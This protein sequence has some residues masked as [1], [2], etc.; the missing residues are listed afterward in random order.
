MESRT[1]HRI[2]QRIPELDGWRVLLVFL[3]SWYHIWQQSWLTPHIGSISLDFLLRS[4]YM[5]VDG[6]VL[7]SGFLLFLPYAEAMAEHSPLP[8]ARAFYRR[9][10]MRI[11]PSYYAFTLIMLF[12][13]ALPQRFYASTGDMLRDLIAH[14]TFT[15]TFTPKTYLGSPLGAASWTLCVE[16]QMYL[17]FPW[18]A[19]ACVKK[20]AATL[21]GLCAA[22]AYWRMWAMWRFTDYGM[23]VNQLASFLDIYAIGMACAIAYVQLRRAW[24]RLNR[25]HLGEVAAT[26]VLCACLYLTVILLKE[27]AR[28][29][30][31]DGIQS[32]QMLRRMPFGLL[33][34]GCMLSLPFAVKPVRLLFG[35]RVMKW[36]SAISMNYYLLHQPL[37]VQLKRLHIPPYVN[38]NPNMASERAWQYPY[39]FV[40]FGLGI[41][42]AALMTLLIEKPCAA[43]LKRAFARMD[44]RR[45]R[46]AA[47]RNA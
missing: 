20:P 23:V 14:F 38:E 1:P 15:F 31:M 13:V 32:G 17:L 10:V 47:G 6:T 33:L 3:V 24:S 4:G 30:G 26:C 35:N 44:A 21:L 25:R 34:G 42:L 18:I 39:T 36:L 27:Q 22:G 41:L 16:T 45:Q 40:C 43:G 9:R 12:A 28:S 29:T 46:K 2:A 37:A 5:P 7:L 11:V 8:S 19:R